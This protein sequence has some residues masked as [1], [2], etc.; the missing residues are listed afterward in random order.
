MP[1]KPSVRPVTP[2]AFAS[3]APARP[4]AYCRRWADKRKRSVKPR[5][6]LLLALL[7]AL[8]ASA[9]WRENGKVIPDTPWAKSDGDFGAMM[10]FTDEPDELFA[11]WQKPGAT[12]K[13]KRTTT[14]VRGVPIVAVVFFTGCGTDAA[15]KCNLV[16][17]FTT[18][19]PSGKDYGDPIDADIWVDLPHPPGPDLQLSHGSMGLVIDPGDELGVYRVRLELTDH[20]SQK[21]MYLEREFT[22]VEAAEPK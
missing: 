22:A 4:A 11:A 17:R 2:L 7:S 9:E 8:S 21:K 12:V 20:V 19:T 14:A 1:M 15:G 3:I 6:V 18:T 16:G 5:T 10:D 13:W